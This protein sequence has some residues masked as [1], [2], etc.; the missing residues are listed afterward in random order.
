MK[1]IFSDIDG[2]LNSDIW[3]S[4]DTI[5]MKN[6]LGKHFDPRC[7][8]LLNK[9]ITNTKSKIVLTSTWRLNHSIEE[10]KELLKQVDF[11]GEVIGL[12]PDLKEKDENFV[13]GNEILKWCRDHEEIIGSSY[14]S[15]TSYVIVDDNTDIYWQKDNYVQVDRYVGLT[16]KKVKE[17]IKIL[18]K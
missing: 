8:R 3:Y 11:N 14:K 5:K 13:G 18:V 9:V 7:I 16:T 6:G 12:T 10:L 15:Y 17:M 1:I 4:G 2:V